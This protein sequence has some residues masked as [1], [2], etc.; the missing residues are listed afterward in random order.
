MRQSFTGAKGRAAK[1]RT[2]G[3]SAHILFRL[4]DARRVCIHT[5]TQARRAH[6]THTGETT[7]RAHTHIYTLALS[8][9]TRIVRADA[10]LTG[11]AASPSAS[12]LTYLSLPRGVSLQSAISYPLHSPSP[13]PVAVPPSR[14]MDSERAAATLSRSARSREKRETRI[15]AVPVCLSICL[16]AGRPV[17]RRTYQLT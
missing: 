13:F 14:R 12:N 7:P 9:T 15:D 10:A 8:R 1:L 5:Y 4:H 2:G 16:A 11:C 3:I 17:G 6:N